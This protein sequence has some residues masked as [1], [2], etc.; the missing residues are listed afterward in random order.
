M[1]HGEID[2]LKG[3]LMSYMIRD[4][5]RVFGPSLSAVRGGIER[6][7]NTVG[8]WYFPTLDAANHFAGALARETGQEIQ[9]LKF[10]GSWAAPVEWTP[11]DDA[12][13]PVAPAGRAE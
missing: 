4:G 5:Y 7:H 2:G 3:K 13:A 10:V 6:D 9:V 11:A 12:P 8:L 1:T